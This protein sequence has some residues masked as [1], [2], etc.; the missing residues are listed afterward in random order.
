MKASAIC[1]TLV[2][3]LALGAAQIGRQATEYKVSA[4]AGS[5]IPHSLYY[6][7]EFDVATTSA[8]ESTHCSLM[9]LG[10]DL[11]PPVRPIGC[12][13]AA[14]SWSVALG[15]ESLALT[16]MT[17]LGEETNLTGVHTITK[18]QLAMLDHGS[19]VIQYYKGPRNFAIATERTLA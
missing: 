3:V 4:F 9:L 17:P 5:C 1:S 6:N 10:P 12:E 14:Y 2:A 11:L 8:L 15:N 13:D 18:D 16:V 7:Y 19:V